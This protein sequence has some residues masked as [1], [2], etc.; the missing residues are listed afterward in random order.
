MKYRWIFFTY[1]GFTTKARKQRQP[2]YF[3]SKWGRKEEMD[4]F[5]PRPKSKISSLILFTATTYG[6]AW[7]R[8]VIVKRNWK[9]IKGFLFKKSN[10]VKKHSADLIIFSKYNL[11]LIIFI[12]IYVCVCVSVCVC[13]CVCVFS[14]IFFCCLKI[15]LKHYWIFC[16]Y[17]YAKVKEMDTVKGMNPII[18]Q[19][20]SGN[21]VVWVS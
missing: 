13:V 15:Y 7:G 6:C 1:C 17:T 14:A 21:I 16:I 12:Y 2:H 8:C 19:P 9:N 3:T 4:T 10:I 20:A 5:F 11:M 18:L